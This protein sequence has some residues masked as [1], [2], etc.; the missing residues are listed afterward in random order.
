MILAETFLAAQGMAPEVA[1]AWRNCALC[2]PDL[3]SAHPRYPTVP[4]RPLPLVDS[5]DVTP[6]Q[7]SALRVLGLIVTVLGGVIVLAAG[8]AFVFVGTINERCPPHAVCDGKGMLMVA[9]IVLGAGGAVVAGR[10]WCFA[11]PCES[12]AAGPQ[13]MT[14]LGRARWFWFVCA[15][16]WGCSRPSIPTAAPLG[17]KENRTGKTAGPLWRPNPRRRG[18]G[19]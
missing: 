12:E 4:G 1:V 11:C 17:A 9:A 14:H 13:E 16:A 2:A 6:S 8:G 19:R 3:C 7:V 15:T 10:G 18:P 5:G